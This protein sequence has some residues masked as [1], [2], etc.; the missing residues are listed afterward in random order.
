M[1]VTK[2]TSEYFITEWLYNGEP[3]YV[4]QWKR[5]D[6]TEIK[7][8]NHFARCNGFKSVADM[9]AQT[10]GKAKFEELFGGV[11]EWIRV[12]PKGDFFFVGMPKEKLN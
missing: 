8:T 7:V 9:A 10:I 11:P 4:R 12:T 5:E 1:K 6:V 2:E 3:I